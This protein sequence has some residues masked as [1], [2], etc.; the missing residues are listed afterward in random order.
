MADRFGQLP[1]TNQRPA[2]HEGLAQTSSVALQSRNEVNEK[3]H[4]A[5]LFVELVAP[6]RYHQVQKGWHL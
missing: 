4:W 3:I 5:F 6:M 1:L 2:L